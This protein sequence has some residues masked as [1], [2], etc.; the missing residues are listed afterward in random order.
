[1]LNQHALVDIKNNLSAKL[2]TNSALYEAELFNALQVI[3]PWEASE[4]QLGNQVAVLRLQIELL[5]NYLANP[6]SQ[7]L[8]DLDKIYQKRLQETGELLCESYADFLKARDYVSKDGHEILLD[9]N[10]RQALLKE[11]QQNWLQEMATYADF[12]FSNNNSNITLP[13]QLAILETQQAEKEE[14]AWLLLQQKSI[15][16][17][18]IQ[19]RSLEY[20]KKELFI[21][22]AYQAIL[23]NIELSLPEL[24][25][26]G[27]LE[28]IKKLIS[29]QSFL[30]KKA[31]INQ[32]GV[33][34]YNALHAACLN[35]HLSVVKYLLEQGANPHQTSDQGY[36]PFHFAVEKTHAHSP[37]LLTLLIKAG[38]AV[39]ATGPYGITPLHTAAFFG[40][41]EGAKLL[42]TLGA[43][44][45][46]KENTEGFGR[47]PLHSA[48]AKGYSTLVALLLEHGANPFARNKAGDIALFEA[49]CAGHAQTAQVFLEHGYWL[50][51]SDFERLVQYVEKTGHFDILKIT[52]DVLMQQTTQLTQHIPSTKVPEQSNDHKKES[53]PRSS[54]S[55]Q[56]NTYSNMTHF[57]SSSN[58]NSN[59]GQDQELETAI[60]L[61]LEQ[62]KEDEVKSKVECNK[63]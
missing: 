7:T 48:A 6:T 13:E 20:G 53:S 22:E 63:L 37:E 11:F 24:A 23:T 40:N 45:N 16:G 25:A 14:R 61:S 5:K 38:C 10:K 59:T 43:S 57:K 35:G 8:T 12:S 30:K 26:T 33:N 54:F 42:L 1:M 60:Q 62:A 9:N 44:V 31:F 3:E 19:V 27:E 17:Q 56:Q 50:P 49:L 29:Q 34:G 46:A 2:E 4:K 21:R 58:N 52:S 51:K 47:T 32:L 18:R 39:N 28:K 15:I 41:V 36:L 55:Y